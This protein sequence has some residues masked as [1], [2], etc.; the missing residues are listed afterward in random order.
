MERIRKYCAEVCPPLSLE[1]IEKREQELKPT[2]W[3]KRLLWEKT[4][5]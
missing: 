1:Q 3:L 4:W 2:V 5:K